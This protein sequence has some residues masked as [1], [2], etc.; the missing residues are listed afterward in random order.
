M[1]AQSCI[2]TPR[3]S[4]RSCATSSLCYLRGPLRRPSASGSR[5]RASRPAGHQGTARGWSCHRLP[6][7]A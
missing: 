7:A 2:P 3:C 1:R 6:P 4:R 5:I